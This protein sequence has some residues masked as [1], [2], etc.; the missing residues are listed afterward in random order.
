MKT[1]VCEICGARGLV[2]KDGLYVCPE[3]GTGYEPEEA[4]GLMVD[5]PDEG[6][7][8]ADPGVEPRAPIEVKPQ[9][10]APAVAEARPSGDAGEAPAQAQTQGE[11]GGCGCGGCL[12]T[13]I[14]IIIISS[15]WNALFG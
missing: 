5:V 12:L 7:G 3:C 8:E 1:I 10:E 4:K 6:G 15:M 2:K 11:T 14:V 13:I 9:A